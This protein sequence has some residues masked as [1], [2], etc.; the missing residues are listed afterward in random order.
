[1]AEME[2]LATKLKP[3]QKKFVEALEKD[4]NATKAAIAAGYT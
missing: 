1:M 2:T 4:G 3:K